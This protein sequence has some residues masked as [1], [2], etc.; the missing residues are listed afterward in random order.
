MP[1]SPSGIDERGCNVIV[2]ITTRCNRAK[3]ISSPGAFWG[4]RRRA[5]SALIPVV[6]T[7][8]FVETSVL[9]LKGTKI[10]SFMRHAY[11]FD[12]IRQAPAP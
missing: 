9:A 4:K 6:S 8:M 7:K 1:P 12:A 5:A 11:K 3:R 2:R 10:L